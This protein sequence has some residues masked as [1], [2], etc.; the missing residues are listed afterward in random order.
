MDGRFVTWSRRRLALG[1]GVLVVTAGFAES[2]RSVTAKGKRRPKPVSR[3]LTAVD[4]SGVGGTVTLRRL[5]HGGTA[6]NVAA[7]GLAEGTNYVSLVYENTTCALEAYS[8]QDYV[9]A[10]YAGDATG[11][12]ST[13]D[14]V[15]DGLHAIGSVSVRLASNFSLLACARIPRARIG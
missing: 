4:N 2:M 13:A 9:G 7:T 5:R 10:V 11:A 8:G 6:V 15:A 12:G 14:H 3:T 1:T